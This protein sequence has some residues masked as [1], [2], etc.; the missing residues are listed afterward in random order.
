MSLEDKKTFNSENKYY[1]SDSFFLKQTLNTFVLLI[2]KITLYL[3]RL[4]I[5]SF[6]FRRIFRYFLCVDFPKKEKKT[7]K[8]EWEEDFGIFL[9]EKVFEYFI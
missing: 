5:Y 1:I 3:T 4:F 9:V 2:L 7:S 8:N 6:N